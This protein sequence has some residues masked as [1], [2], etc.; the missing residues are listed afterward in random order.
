M[1][2]AG[3]PYGARAAAAEIGKWIGVAVN[4]E[5][6]STNVEEVVGDGVGVMEDLRAGHIV[7]REDEIYPP[8]SIEGE[9]EILSNMSSS[10][11]SST[12]ASCISESS[13]FPVIPPFN[14]TAVSSCC[15][16]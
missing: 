13:L 7:G 4:G 2:P 15:I 10:M 16:L 1:P 6:E 5:E 8:S 14:L 3:I 9:L 11:S 12:S